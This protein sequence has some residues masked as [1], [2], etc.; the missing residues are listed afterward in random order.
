MGLFPSTYMAKC[1]L[2]KG[3]KVRIVNS[4]LEKS[5]LVFASTGELIKLTNKLV[6]FLF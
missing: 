2:R 1:F 6:T 3:G 4:K 5:N